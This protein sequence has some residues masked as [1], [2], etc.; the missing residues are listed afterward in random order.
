[1]IVKQSLQH[2]GSPPKAY[3]HTAP[4]FTRTVPKCVDNFRGSW[5]FVP[6]NWC[7]FEMD[8]KDR[9]ILAELQNDAGQSVEALAAKVHLSRNACWRR[10]KAL[11]E[12]GI[13]R[14]RV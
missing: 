11:E 9:R 7:S 1:M 8:N 2:C 5:D 6:A 10:I 4:Q 3:S 12:R 14:A 13:I